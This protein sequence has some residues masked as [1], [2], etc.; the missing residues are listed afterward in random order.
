M[1]LDTIEIP[2]TEESVE[3]EI[4]VGKGFC[5]VCGVELDDKRKRWCDDHK[6]QGNK[7]PKISS[8]K[9]PRKG[10]TAATSELT[11]V[12]GKLLL[13]ITAAYAWS[14]LRRM[15]VRDPGGA[16]AESLAMTDDEAESV[17]RPIARA[18]NSSPVGVRY[19][20]KIVDN[21]DLID[22][23]FALYEWYQ[24]Q[25][26]MLEGLAAQVRKAQ[27]DNVREMRTSNVPVEE[28]ARVR[29]EGG[30]VVPTSGIDAGYLGAVESL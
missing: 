9:E 12:F 29:Q 22:A 5:R 18:F 17:A 28:D 3:L 19:G 15:N 24:R 14:Q 30:T 26:Q 25:S 16:F 8:N 20:R 10:K 11:T 6:G 23:G 27:P 4:D 7:L 21:S 13:L 2:T 1:E